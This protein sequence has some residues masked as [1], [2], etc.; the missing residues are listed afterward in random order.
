MI[1]MIKTIHDANDGNLASLENCCTI[2]K[3]FMIKLNEGHT[4]FNALD[5]LADNFI[6]MTTNT[7]IISESIKKFGTKLSED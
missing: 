7:K 5:E 3:D 1:E 6:G 2:L 4:D